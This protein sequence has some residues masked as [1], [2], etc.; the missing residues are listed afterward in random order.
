MLTPI[1]TRVAQYIVC[2]YCRDK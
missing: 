2:V 1:V